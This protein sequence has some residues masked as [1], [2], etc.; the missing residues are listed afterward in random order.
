MVYSTMTKFELNFKLAHLLGLRPKRGRE[1]TVRLCGVKLVDY[2]EVWNDIMPI[3]IDLG[4][5][6]Q[7]MKNGNIYINK[8]DVMGM[9]FRLGSGGF[10]MSPQQVIVV[11]CIEAL[12]E[13]N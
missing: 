2:C 9:S 6:I 12:L 8:P 5:N 11:C 13:D 3:A 7:H 1:D 10:E 4:V